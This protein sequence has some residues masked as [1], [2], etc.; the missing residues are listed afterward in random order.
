M[1]NNGPK[2]SPKYMMQLISEIETKLWSMFES[3]KYQNIRRYILKWHEEWTWEEHFT[4][5]DENFHI[6]YRDD[7]KSEMDLAETLHRMDE[8]IVFRIATD[9]GIDVPTMLP[10]IAIIKNNVKEQNPNVYE[11][12]TAATKKVY[13]EPDM[14][15]VHAS[16]ALDDIIK[17]ILDDPKIDSSKVLQNGS[18]SKQIK[19]LLD[20]LGFKDDSE[21]EEIKKVAS[22]LRGIVSTIDKIRSSK[23]RVHGKA[24][25]DYIIDNPLWSVFIVN[26]CATVGLLLWSYYKE[27]YPQLET[28]D[29]SN[30][31]SEIEF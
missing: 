9:L 28:E 3:S 1:D 11:N 12:F 20:A 15:V 10:A 6:F 17:A 25:D 5:E 14:A 19:G 4:N 16:S 29:S 21:S 8:D 31:E 2:I 26:A 30:Q 24:G 23:T 27:K 18:L 7:A 22:Q 13:D